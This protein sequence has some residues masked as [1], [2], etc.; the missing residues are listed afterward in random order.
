[1]TTDLALDVRGV[2]KRFGDVQAV[3]GLDLSV[4]AGEV[5]G[6][7]GA[8]GAGKTTLLRIL[9]GLV[10]LDGGTVRLLGHEI[11][12]PDARSPDGVGGFVEEPRFYPYLT[13]RRNLELMADLDGGGQER[14][15]EVLATVRLDDRADRKV[16]GFSS[17]M[18]QRLG[19]ASSLLRRPRILLLD[20]PTIGL[21]PVG[22]RDMLSIVRTLAAGGVTVVLSSHNMSELEGV[23]DGVTVMRDGRAVWQGSMDRLREE[24][25]APAHRLETSDDIRAAELAAEDPRLDVVVDPG[26]WLTVT[27]DRDALDAYAVSLGKAGIA[28]RRLELLMT[29]LESMF[30]SLTGERVEQ[31][32]VEREPDEVSAAG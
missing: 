8:N 14:I 29:A 30:F 28:V 27:A 1:M 11:D 6:L 18:R 20:E 31:P 10:A 13:A 17:G 21:D 2:R 16:A 22:A 32:A 24:S 7:V 9:F 15:D 12:D 19:L 26:G 3:D 4:N 23:C 25:P 5:H